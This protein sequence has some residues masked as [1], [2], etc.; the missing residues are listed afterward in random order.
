[1]GSSELIEKIRADGRQRVAEIER[2]R[3]RQVAEITTRRDAEVQTLESEFHERGERETRLIRERAR[4][5]AKLDARKVLLAAKWEAIGR[6]FAA[7][8]ERIPSDPEYPRLLR[9]IATRHAEPGT[10]VR[11]SESDRAKHGPTLGV[12]LG[13]PAPIAGGVLV[14]QGRETVDYSLDESLAMLRSELASAIA[15]I[16]FPK[17]KPAE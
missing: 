11:L 17:E 16:L 9:E 6:V 1:M 15:R 13:E 4:S 2:E 12:E 7:A 10:V 5:R 8:R 3:E 14:V